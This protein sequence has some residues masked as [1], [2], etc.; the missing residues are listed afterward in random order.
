MVGVSRSCSRS[1]ICRSSRSRSRLRRRRRHRRRQA[2]HPRHQ[3]RLHHPRHRLNQRSRTTTQRN[4]TTIVP[5]RGGRQPRCRRL[6]GAFLPSGVST[7]TSPQLVTRNWGRR[8]LTR[9]LG[10]GLSTSLP[11]K[12]NP[13][14]GGTR[15]ISTF[16]H[17]TGRGVRRPPRAGLSTS[18][19]SSNHS[20]RHVR[21]ALVR[22]S[23]E[24]EVWQHYL[25][26]LLR[27]GIRSYSSHSDSSL[28]VG[29]RRHVQVQVHAVSIVATQ[30]LTYS[31]G[32]RR[33]L[34]LQGGSVSAQGRHTLAVACSR[35]S[36][37]SR[38]SLRRRSSSR[39]RLRSYSRSLGPITERRRAL[40]FGL[41][42]RQSN[43][44]IRSGRH[45]LRRGRRRLLSQDGLGR[46]SLRIGA[47]SSPSRRLR[48]HL[49]RHRRRR[50]RVRSAKGDT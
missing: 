9:A 11:M 36:T 37:Q 5:P 38:S 41:R 33:S 2:P 6:G 1:R 49:G 32:G 34:R 20:V 44:R 28:Q 47:R 14:R 48:L 50:A 13:K 18:H 43:L 42:S 24:L 27:H 40:S 4:R 35:S 22:R 3:I 39:S 29:L 23:R 7:K 45:S 25:D 10:P 17:L 15:A 12:P 8:P 30:L 19:S 31:R 16:M 46:S 26:R 21:C